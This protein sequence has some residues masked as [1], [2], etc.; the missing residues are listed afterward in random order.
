MGIA[1]PIGND[2]L[3]VTKALRDNRSGVQAMP[4]W[5]AHADLGPRVAA[6]VTGVDP[7][8]SIPRKHRRSMGRVAQLCAYATA[9][10]VAQAGLDEALL[11]SGRTGLAVGSTTGSPEATLQ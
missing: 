10:A 3:S 5:E 9:Q 1:S 11:S 4:D 8:D 7:A 6:L 2:I